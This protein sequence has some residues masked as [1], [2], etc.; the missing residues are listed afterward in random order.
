MIQTLKTCPMYHPRLTILGTIK[1]RTNFGHI[2]MCHCWRWHEV[3]N[4]MSSEYPQKTASS[5]L[6][7]VLF[8]VWW[9]GRGSHACTR[10]YDP[11]CMCTC[12]RLPSPAQKALVET[13]L[14]SHHT[15]NPDC[16]TTKNVFAENR[17]SIDSFKF[18]LASM[19]RHSKSN[20]NSGFELSLLLTS[21][22][23]SI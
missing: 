10:L 14:Y 3:V 13:R 20:Q 21:Q 17:S 11:V 12:L 8:G 18:G 15:T 19:T 22:T 6:I 7:T 2:P 16:V 9:F 23:L 4:V 1:Q 5:L